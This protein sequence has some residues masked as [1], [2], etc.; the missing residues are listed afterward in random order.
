[1]SKLGKN[2][3]LT[4]GLGAWIFAFLCHV[5][6][7]QGDEDNGLKN[8]A[9]KRLFDHLFRY[10]EVLSLFCLNSGINCLEK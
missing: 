8:N 6:G 5:Q 1:M 3:L 9:E 4:V 7:V 10:V 2:V